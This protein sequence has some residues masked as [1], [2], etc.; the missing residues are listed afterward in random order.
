[1]GTAPEDFGSKFVPAYYKNA[2]LSYS[3]ISDV[4]ESKAYASKTVP[5][6]WGIKRGA[7]KRMVDTIQ[8]YTVRPIANAR[9]PGSHSA[10]LTY[11]YTAYLH[12]HERHPNAMIR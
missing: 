4:G 3:L 8:W 11:P 12:R 1:M 5:S 2:R 7:W 10:M 6:E 9:L